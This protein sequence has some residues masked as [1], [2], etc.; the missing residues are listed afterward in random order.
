MQTTR[1]L[2]LSRAETLVRTR[3]YAGFS[4]ADIADAVEIRKASVHHHFPNKGDLGA[5]LLGA[6]HE[7]FR[8]L[9]DEIAHQHAA[10]GPRLRAYAALYRQGLAQGLACLCGMLASELPLLPE[11]VQR[12]V[13]RF[14]LDHAAWLAE[15]LRAGQ[16]AGELAPRVQP[17][18]TAHALLS[19]WQGAM[20]LARTLGD[21]EVFRAA[22]EDALGRVLA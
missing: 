11:E 21:P 8:A 20:F 18:P 19:T 7:R 16:Q 6:Y 10:T 1:E 2:I 17:E 3:G 4:Y 15:V 22:S 13:R 5:A 14:F 9:M 12:G